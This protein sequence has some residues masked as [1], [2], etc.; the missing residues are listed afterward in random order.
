MTYPGIENDPAA[1][2]VNEDVAAVEARRREREAEYGE[3]V[4]KTNIPWGTVLA[5]T[6]GMPVPASTVSRLKWDEMDLVVKRNTKAGR[7]VLEATG[8]ATPDELTKW[9]DDDKAA[10]A[11]Q[12]TDANTTTTANAKAGS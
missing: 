9:A 4:A 11:R 6:P 1:L 10:T 12:K 3:W 2:A 8:T 7:E 5:F